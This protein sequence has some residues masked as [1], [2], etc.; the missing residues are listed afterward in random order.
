[1][2][3]EI[4]K[5]GNSR[6]IRIPKHILEECEILDSVEAEVRNG[7]LHLKATVPRMNCEKQ[8]INSLKRYGQDDELSSEN[9]INLDISEG[10]WEW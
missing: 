4:V 8:F 6:G 3:L 1:M 10:E 5:I 2:I 7:V 9:E